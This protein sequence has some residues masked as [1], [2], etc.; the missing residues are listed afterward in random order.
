MTALSQRKLNAL[1]LPLAYVDRQ[2]ALPLRQ[3]ARSSTGSASAHDEVVGHE[4]IEVVGREV[5]QLYHAYIDAALDGER[6]SFERQLVAPGRPP[7][8]IRVD[9]YPD[10]GAA[11][12]RP[13]LPRHVQPTSTT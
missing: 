8:W 2:A 1:G 13:R 3:Q 11:R 5:Y 12:P 7:I 6:T 4:V 9:Y 10:R